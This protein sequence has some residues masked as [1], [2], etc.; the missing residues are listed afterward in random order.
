[1]VIHLDA[2]NGPHQA[3]EEQAVKQTLDKRMLTAAELDAVSG[4]EL[5]WRCG[6]LRRS[7][8]QR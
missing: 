7:R 2:R 4:G 1:M 5:V 3:K 6:V 8:V